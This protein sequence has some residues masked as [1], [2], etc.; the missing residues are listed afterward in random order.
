VTCCIANKICI[1]SQECLA[2]HYDASYSNKPADCAWGMYDQNCFDNY[3]NY[4][5]YDHR[6]TICTNIPASNFLPKNCNTER[7]YCRAQGDPHY[8]TFDGEK[9]DFMGTCTYLLSGV[10]NNSTRDQTLPGFAVRTKHTGYTRKHDVAMIEHV[11]IDIHS[12]SESTYVD[13]FPTY[14]LHFYVTDPPAKP[15]GKGS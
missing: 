2:Y 9:F 1:S 3:E 12:Q 7:G 6:L 8:L 5:D 13:D 4:F 14:T 15:D 11:W 10:P